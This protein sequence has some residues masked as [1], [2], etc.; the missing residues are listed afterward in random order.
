MVSL[1]MINKPTNWWSENFVSPVGFFCHC[2][3][4]FH[5]RCWIVITLLVIRHFA[6][7]TPHNRRSCT[8]VMVLC[9]ACSSGSP[10][11]ATQEV[12]W[13]AKAGNFLLGGDGANHRH[14]AARPGRSVI[15][16]LLWRH[17]GHS[18][19]FVYVCSLQSQDVHQRVQYLTLAPSKNTS[20]AARSQSVPPRSR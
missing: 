2:E 19:Y 20:L 18:E 11:H 5:R 10:P 8:V 13:H 14:C 15:C 9:V 12:D 3:Q 17:K 16:V 6:D 1:L 7:F 4:F